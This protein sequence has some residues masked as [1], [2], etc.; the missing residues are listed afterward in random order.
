M[1]PHLVQAQAE[2]SDRKE[3]NVSREEA[4]K[5][6]SPAGKIIV[7]SNPTSPTEL[8]KAIDQLIIFWDRQ[9]AK[10]YAAALA[11]TVAATPDLDL[12]AIGDQSGPVPLLKIIHTT[13]LDPRA[14]T[15][16]KNVLAAVRERDIDPQRLKDLADKTTSDDS[17]ERRTAVAQLRAAGPDA[18]A[19]LLQM[20]LSS[21]PRANRAAES[22]LIGLGRQ[23]VPPMLAAL[24]TKNKQFRARLLSILSQLQSSETTN[25]L[26]IE[27]LTS[28]S[29][30]G[31]ITDPTSMQIIE[32]V[33]K[34]IDRALSD[35]QFNRSSVASQ[36]TLWEWNDEQPVLTHR[37]VS[38]FLYSVWSAYRLA[39]ALSQA[40]PSDETILIEGTAFLE[41]EKLN[42]GLNKPISPGAVSKFKGIAKKYSPQGDLNILDFAEAVF[43][44]AIEK[45]Y[46]PAAIAAAEVLANVD[47][48][49]NTKVALLT[50]RGAA[51][52][53]LIVALGQ[54][55]R[56]LRMACCKAILHLTSEYPFVGAGT[57]SDALA[58]FATA[59]G[60][61]RILI[62]DNRTS[63]RQRLISLFGTAGY[64]TLAT[65]SGREAVQ[66][67]QNQPDCVVGFIASNVGTQSFQDIIHPLRLDAR[68]A[69]LPLAILAD[70]DELAQRRLEADPYPLTMCVIAPQ[71]ADG[72]QAD[73]DTLVDQLGI[74]FVPEQERLEEA[75]LAIQLYGELIRRIPDSGTTDRWE[76][77]LIG[78]LQVEA[79]ATAATE[80]LA[81]IKTPAA[82]RGLVDA[83]SATYLPLTT[84]QA[85]AKA[86]ERNVAKHGIG[87]SAAEI[88]KQ[89]D[90]YDA[91]EGSDPEEE[92]LLWS[93]LEAINRRAATR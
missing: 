87:L 62:A 15:F 49:N 5:P 29:A 28:K 86:F 26:L 27:K 34:S 13:E 22:A 71:Q 9:Q 2:T 39:Q 23:A 91:T 48:T 76:Q 84:R 14:Q 93:I 92:A 8:I 60:K 1:L 85:A 68:T 37:E 78:S 64:K 43:E 65:T 75:R 12:V 67:A 19:P 56:R 40:A 74:F 72:A 46:T 24:E 4:A 61:P 42:Q 59:D 69:Q 55:D 38:S 89:K 6:L 3:K 83:A 66:A 58:Y 80:V 79:L 7:D 20:L 10:E 45:G 54:K 47:A 57:L 30:A 21:E 77:I 31:S 82:Q 32:R 35:P 50:R 36:K 33:K 44:R 73:I 90:R 88:Q 16:C 11:D 25:D 41:W 18:V 81:Q 52:H 17:I 53:P 70:P 51:P 63:R